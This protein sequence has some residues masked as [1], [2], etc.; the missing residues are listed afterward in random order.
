MRRASERAPSGDAGH[1]EI[2]VSAAWEVELP[3]A[4]VE[5]L[6]LAPGDLLSIEPGAIALRL[7]IYREFLAGGWEGLAAETA[8]QFVEDF[9]SRPLTA[10]GPDG[11]LP[12]PADLLMLAPGDRAAL[13]V[14]CRGP[15]YELYLSREA[16]DGRR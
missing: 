9:L 16:T 8:S 11:R 13:Q 10:L 4:V 12:I 7:E 5:R 2:T 1:V 6:R 15:C 3:E 14:V